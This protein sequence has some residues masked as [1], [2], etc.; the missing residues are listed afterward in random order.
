MGL[1]V[2]SPSRLQT[3]PQLPFSSSSSSSSLFP[4][5]RKPATKRLGY[6]VC[7][8]SGES[9][10]GAAA[11]ASRRRALLLVGISVL[12]FLK[13]GAMAAEGL[14]V[15]GQSKFRLLLFYSFDLLVTVTLKTLASVQVEIS[16]SLS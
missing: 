1:L 15:D 14:M 3:P 12:P 7:C 10:V 9:D 11:G 13:L 4:S 16:F 5:Q 8:T 6:A 2:G